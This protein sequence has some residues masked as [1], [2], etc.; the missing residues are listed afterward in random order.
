MWQSDYK[1]WEEAVQKWAD[2]FNMAFAQLDFLS[3]EVLNPQD[4]PSPF[5]AKQCLEGFSAFLKKINK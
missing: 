1:G 4:L 2:C 5:L 3:A